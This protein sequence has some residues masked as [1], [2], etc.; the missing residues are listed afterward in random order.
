MSK[1]LSCQSR[2]STNSAAADDS[3]HRFVRA[4]DSLP[5]LPQVPIGEACSLTARAN[6]EAIALFIQPCTTGIWNGER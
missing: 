3:T 1:T 2:T 6:A 5:L 4:A